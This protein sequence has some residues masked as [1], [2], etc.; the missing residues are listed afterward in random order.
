MEA[1]SQFRIL[2]IAGFGV[3]RSELGY[4]Q[5]LL[6]VGVL[7]FGEWTPIEAK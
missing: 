6:I 2:R 7:R 3:E 4:E 1:I 5:Y